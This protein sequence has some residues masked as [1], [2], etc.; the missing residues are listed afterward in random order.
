MQQ[1]LSSVADCLNSS[2]NNIVFGNSYYLS[3]TKGY[4]TPTGLFYNC[5]CLQFH[6][7]IFK[8]SLLATIIKLIMVLLF[9]TS[10][11]ANNPL[12]N[13]IF[14]RNVNFLENGAVSSHFENLIFSMFVETVV[15]PELE[16]QSLNSSKWGHYELLECHLCWFS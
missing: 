4:Y 14:N 16:C 2:N 10:F 7:T 6:Q 1:Q 8:Y 3:F 9:S 11:G 15:R 5:L 13:L 12:F